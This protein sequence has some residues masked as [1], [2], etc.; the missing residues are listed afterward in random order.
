MDDDHKSREELLAELAALREQQAASQNRTSEPDDNARF[1]SLFEANV[2]G[3]FFGDLDGHIFEAN[4]AFLELL[5]YARGDVESQPLNWKALVPPD[6]EAK[7]ATH[8]AMLRETGICPACEKQLLRRDGTRISVW[9]G[10]AQLHDNRNKGFGFVLDLTEQHNAQRALKQ[11]QQ[12]FKSLFEHHPDA[13]L[14][15]DLEGRYTLVNPACERISGYTREELLHMNFAAMIAPDALENSAQSFARVLT[16]ETTRNETVLIGKDG[17]RIEMTVIGIP[18]WVDGEIVGVYGIAREITE[19]KQAESALRASEERYRA[20]VGQSSEAIWRFEFD[21]PVSLDLPPNE[22]VEQFYRDGYLAECNDAM[23]RMYGFAGASDI[24][25]ARLGDLMPDSLENRAYLK[26]WI[27]EGYRLTNADSHERD[28]DGQEKVFSN[29]FVGI[30]EKGLLLRAWG[31]QRDVTHSRRV[32]REARDNHQHLQLALRA[33]RMGTWE[34]NAQM[35]LVSW[36][37]EIETLFGIEPGNLSGQSAPD[38]FQKLIHPDDWQ[39]VLGQALASRESGE[40]EVEYRVIW[41]DGSLHWIHSLG[42]AQHDENVN[43]YRLSGTS[44]DITAQKEAEFTQS[45]LAEAGALF[46]S[47][48]DYQTTLQNVANLIVPRFADLCSI[49]IAAD[50]GTIHRLAIVGAD[51]AKAEVLMAMRHASLLDTNAKMGPAHAIRTGETTFVQHWSQSDA[52]ANSRDDKARELFKILDPKSYI[53]TPMIAGGKTVGAIN[54]IHAES[55]RVYNS[56]DLHLARAIADRAALAVENARLY[57]QADLARREAEIANRAKD[58]FLAVVSH[59]LRTP[60]TPMLGWLDLMR[61]ERSSAKPWDAQRWEHAVEVLDRNAR[62]QYQLVN[63]LLDV[64]RIVSGNLRLAL[65]PVALAPLMRAAVEA[66]LPHA[67]ARDIA[68]ET[69]FQHVGDITGDAERLQQIIANLLANA[70]KFTPEG[71]RIE[72]VLETRDAQTCIS[73]RDWGIG[74]EA[75]FLPH[76]FERFRQ[77]DASTT[78]RHG[79]LGLG[80]SIVRHLVELHGGTVQ[81]QSDGRGH[82]ATFTV[83]LPSAATPMPPTDEVPEMHRYAEKTARVL[84]GVK[85]LVVDNEVDAREMFARALADA[86]AQV[87]AVGSATDALASIQEWQPHVLIS[88]IGMPDMDGIELMRRVRALPGE[89]ATIPAIALTAYARDQDRQRTLVAGFDLHVAKPADTA[90]L[91]TTVARLAQREP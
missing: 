78:R 80:L 26:Q 90:L 15:L 66:V 20:F 2:L 40:Y 16:G 49:D 33:G 36:S 48:L 22:Q 23:A 30:I 29:N 76:I 54:F 25:G 60:L 28:R 8:V 51:A 91:I 21:V 12:R 19:Q 41:P 89:A 68:V 87:Q 73:V 72:V 1:R 81:A 63:D 61:K 3:V 56:G 52:N 65:A 74:I 24:V 39:Y 69:R 67:T 7:F 14:A 17:R 88:D 47:S 5:G 18:I 70:V 13:I 44:R 84:D 42:L 10:A 82:G 38:I 64:S 58:E 32:A 62:L 6:E 35:Q 37:E 9:M 83:C 46:V 50:D 27:G 31:T 57:Q 71:G 55:G 34:W 86:G 11:T 45:F 77:A 59:E 4:D 43:S 85:I 79:G 75:D 53:C